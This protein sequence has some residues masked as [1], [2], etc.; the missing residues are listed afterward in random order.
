M[1]QFI[2][3]LAIAIIVTAAIADAASICGL[4]HTV[5]RKPFITILALGVIILA[6][7]LANRHR[8]ASRIVDFI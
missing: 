1:V 5:V 2:A 3:I 8:I 7:A 6:A 4:A